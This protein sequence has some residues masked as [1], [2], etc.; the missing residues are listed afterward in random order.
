MGNSHLDDAKHWRARAA[1]ARLL[2]L[3]ITDANAKAMMLDTA[4][5][6]EKIARHAELRVGD[7]KKPAEMNEGPPRPAPPVGHP[8][9]R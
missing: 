9:P 3:Q 7:A 8:T 1:E 2:A 4:L 5:G 6:Y